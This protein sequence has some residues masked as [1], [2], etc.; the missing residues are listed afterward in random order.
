[1]VGKIFLPG[2]LLLTIIHLLRTHLTA[3]SGSRRRSTL[4]CHFFCLGACALREEVVVTAT[5]G[6]EEGGRGPRR[7]CGGGCGGGTAG[8]FNESCLGHV[9]SHGSRCGRKVDGLKGQRRAEG[10]QKRG[11][12]EGEEGV[13]GKLIAAVA[14][15]VISVG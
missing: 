13:T 3:T 10:A 7:A 9:R 11:P 12:T 14:S 1:V 5:G 15:L 2:I 4:A 6:R 8:H